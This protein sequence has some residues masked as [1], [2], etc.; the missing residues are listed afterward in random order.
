MAADWCC[1]CGSVPRHCGLMQTRSYL[2]EEP[3]RHPTCRWK[4]SQTC[5]P[6]A[7]FRAGRDVLRSGTGRV[8]VAMRSSG[9]WSVWW[10][11]DWLSVLLVQFV[12]NCI[13]RYKSSYGITFGREKHL[14]S[15]EIFELCKIIQLKISWL[16]Y[17]RPSFM[18]LC[19]RVSRWPLRK[20]NFVKRSLPSMRGF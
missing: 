16:D 15:S 19:R 10:D 9:L 11:M 17:K 4:S 18:R 7:G 5:F 2:H 13:R 12:A 8:V 3:K 1:Y 20:L 6:V 14:A